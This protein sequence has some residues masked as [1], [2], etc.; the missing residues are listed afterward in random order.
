MHQISGFDIGTIGFYTPDLP[1]VHHSSMFVGPKMAFQ[2]PYQGLVS[3]ADQVSHSLNITASRS[4]PSTLDISWIWNYCVHAH[5]RLQLSCMPP[6]LV[7]KVPP[8]RYISSLP[9]RHCRQHAIPA[10]TSRRC[11]MH[12]FWLLSSSCS[13]DCIASSYCTIGSYIISHHCVTR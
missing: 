6:I 12:Q 8:S 4:N 10:A 2:Y 7:Y 11:C 9:P 5:S 1:I 13:L 3:W